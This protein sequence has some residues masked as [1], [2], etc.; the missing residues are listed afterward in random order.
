MYVAGYEHRYR[1]GPEPVEKAIEEDEEQQQAG[2]DKEPGDRH[3]DVG[4]EVVLDASQQ[5]E[6]ERER[7][8]EQC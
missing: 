7:P 8:D 6:R 4:D 1:D 5:R 2:H 3:A